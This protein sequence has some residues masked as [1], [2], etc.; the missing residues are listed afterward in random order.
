[1]NRP[2]IML[3]TDTDILREGSAVRARMARYGSL[4]SEL[5]II[6]FSIKGQSAPS[7]KGSEIAPHV[8]IYP[9]DSSLKALFIKDGIRIAG[10]LLKKVPRPFVVSTQDP[11]ETSIIG[12]YMKAKASASGAK[13]QVQV[14]TDLFSPLFIKTFFLNSIRRAIASIALRRADGIRVVSSRIQKSIIEKMRIP[15]ERITILPVY[16]NPNAPLEFP[17]DAKGTGPYLRSKYPQF[18]KI[19]LAVSRLTKEKDSAWLIGTLSVT[20]R[21]D[22]TL[23]LVIVG[24]GPD[25]LAL[26]SEIDALG[27]SKQII[28][29][30]FAPQTRAFFESADVFVSSS[31]YE[32][33]GLTYIEALRAGLPIVSTDV[34][35]TTDLAQKS[36]AVFVSAIDDRMTFLANIEKALVLPSDDANKKARAEVLGT[37]DETLYVPDEARYLELYGRALDL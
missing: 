24:R 22:P 7:D 12:M 15:A 29:E 13:L 30:G 34:G 3:S 11:F 20:L 33:Y 8:Y 31:L 28:L 32:G 23:G 19:L 1:M 26:D 2:V 4:C 18:K 14:H 5:H 6:L 17:K 36:D 25:R 37:L 35:I 9:T 10:E 16:S 21:K 27:L